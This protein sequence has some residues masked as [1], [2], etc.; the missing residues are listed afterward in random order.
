MKIFFKWVLMGAA[1]LLLF[2]SIYVWLNWS[3]VAI[4]MGTEGITGKTEIIPAASAQTLVPLEKG[5]ADWATWLGIGGNS[6]STVTSLKTDWSK[7]LQKLWEVD[8]LCQ[9]RTSAA[10]AAPV[11]QGNRLVVTGR[12][13]DEDL[14]F[15]LDPQDGHLLWQKSYSSKA[16]TSHGAGPRATP[17]IEDN[18][19]YTFG[20]NGDLVCWNLTDGAEIWKANVNG[21]G[22]ETPQWG[23][24]SSPLILGDLVLV[25]G[26]GSART[27]AFDKMTGKVLWK[28]GNGKSGYAALTKIMLQNKAVILAFHGT[29]LAAIDAENGAELWNIP[30]STPYDVNATTPVVSENRV[31]IT[32]GYKTGGILLEASRTGGKKI[33]Q[34]TSI[35]AQHSDPFVIDGYLYGYSGDSSQNRGDFVCVE[36]A[37]GIEK[38]RS[39]EM[40][41]GTCIFAAGYLLCQDIRG[42][43]YLMQPNFDKFIKISEL[44]QALGKVR[45]PVWTRP[46]V[47]NGRLYLRFKQMLVCY[48]I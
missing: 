29:G 36:L 26:G 3:S 25:Q 18:R 21:L 30:W 16:G 44:P 41:W 1:V 12:S 15:C 11:I 38:W 19:V 13:A 23:H 37:T 46:V 42:N 32:S 28:S 7:G 20:R 45:G 9:G 31:F 27:L 40:G 24:S 39:G 17:A 43:L 2:L 5:P 48:E 33:W 6:R 4:L 34:N 10:W 22:G 14:I 47:A 8:F 35:A